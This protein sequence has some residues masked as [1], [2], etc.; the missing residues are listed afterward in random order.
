LAHRGRGTCTVHGLS[1]I[2]ASNPSYG[3]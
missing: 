2:H 1:A 3:Q